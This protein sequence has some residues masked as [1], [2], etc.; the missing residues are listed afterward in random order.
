MLTISELFIYPIKSMSGISVSSAKVTDRGL[1]NDRRWMLVDEKNSFLTLREFPKMALIQP[2]LEKKCL[3][4]RFTDSQVEDLTIPYD[5][6]ENGWEKV[7]IWNANCD[8]RR[9]GGDADR[10]FSEILGTNCKLVFMPDES[11]RPVDTTS[12]FKPEGKITSFSDAYPFLMLGEASV[13]DLNS[14]LNKPVSIKRFRPN[15]VFSGGYPFQ[16][17]KIREFSINQ[18]RFT[19]LENCARCSIPNVDP[20]KGIMALD[21]E[22][23]KTLATYRTHDKT[24][25][26]GRNVAHS[27]TGMISVGDEICLL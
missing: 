18:V 17:D 7:T 14:R 21:K 16:E 24:I 19:G 3:R 23:L 10:W 12:G 15:I 5:M 27:G 13:N 9:I 22:P 1:E 2:F 11:I 20:E 4:I 6:F 8:A 26:F 25:N